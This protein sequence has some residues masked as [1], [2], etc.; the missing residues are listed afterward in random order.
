VQTILAISSYGMYVMALCCTS[1]MTTRHQPRVFNLFNFDKRVNPRD[2]LIIKNKSKIY[3][4]YQQ[5]G[6]FTY[7]F[8][9]IQD[10]KWINHLDNTDDGYLLVI[11]TISNSL[12]LYNTNNGNKLW[13]KQLQE[14]I[15]QLIIDPHLESRIACKPLSA[16]ILLDCFCRSLFIFK[17]PNFQSIKM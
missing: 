6:W 17:L 10:I 4:I 13:S 9:S 5:K 3:L 11:Y 7:I 15:L 1:S 8:K 2:P 16:L 12:V 14:P